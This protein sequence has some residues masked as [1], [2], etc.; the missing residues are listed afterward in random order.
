MSIPDNRRSNFKFQYLPDYAKFI[1]DNK[2]DEFVLIGIRFARE[3]DLPMLRPLER[4]SEQQLLELSRE[5]NKE[6]LES[7]ANNNIV[8]FID[9]NIKAYVENS[10]NDKSG[11]KLLDST[12]IVAEDIILAFYIRRKLLSFFLHAYTQ[13]AVLHVLIMNEVDYY[14]TMEHLYTTKAYLENTAVNKV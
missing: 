3:L 6:I 1:L 11:K 2:L 12:E 9:K 5:S 10:L 4:L 14:T 8:P 7:L 13:N